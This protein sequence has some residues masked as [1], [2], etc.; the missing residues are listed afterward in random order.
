MSR[1]KHEEMVPLADMVWASF[2]RDQ[3]EIEAENTTFTAAYLNDF[4]VMT[5]EVRDLEQSDSLLT[6]QKGVTGQLYL[7]ANGMKK[8]L[9]LFQIV[10]KK[11]GLDTKVVSVLLKNISTRNMEGALVNIKS[12]EQIV[13]GNTALLNSTGMKAGFP[14]FLSDHFTMLTDLSNQ[15]NQIMKDRKLLT[16]DNHG[17]YAALQVFISD[18]CGVGKTVYS[19]TI[20]GEEYN[21]TKL[22]TKLHS[23]GGKGAASPPPTP[24]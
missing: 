16:D 14:T 15:Q 18:V 9:K 24:A 12:M 3:A 23:S 11:S 7:A 2:K 21:V 17:S 20:K 8:D 4:K 1:I 5:D 6:T 13:T 10:L 19:G 22:L